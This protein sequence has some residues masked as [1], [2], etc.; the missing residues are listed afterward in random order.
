MRPRP[1]FANAVQ[2]VLLTTC[3]VV[4][5]LFPALASCQ[6]RVTPTQPRGDGNPLPEAGYYSA[7]ADYY[8]GEYRRAIRQYQRL[9]R[10][11]YQD[12]D[13]P[14]LDSVCY[15]TMLGECYYQA[16]DYASAIEMYES[17]IKIYIS[18]SLW[19]PRTQVPSTIAA[20]NTA[21]AQ[22][23]VTWYSSTRSTQIGN[24]PRNYS[25]LF[26]RLDNGR[27]LNEGGVIQ[28]P[29]ARPVDISEAMRCTALSLYRRRQIKG[30]IAKHDP[31]TEQIAKA[32]S[33]QQLDPSNVVGTW[34]GVLAGL[35]YAAAEDW[36]KAA[37]LL[38]QS[39]QVGGTY[40][41]PLTPIALLELGN[42]SFHAGKP[43]D[44]VKLYLEAS[45][46]A[47]VH[48]QYDL[49]E[50]S[51]RLAATTFQLE[52]KSSVFEPLGNA[53]SW[54]QRENADFLQASLAIE[55]AYNLA[56]LGN[57]DQAIRMLASAEQPMARNDIGSST[58]SARM[59]FVSALTQFQAGK[60]SAGAADFA[61]FLNQY[62]E[63]GCLWIYQLALADGLVVSKQ[64]SNR[65]ADALYSLL[66]REPSQLD[67]Q[68]QPM[69]TLTYELTDHT[70]PLE[71]WFNI[72]MDQRKIEKAIDVS[73][74][75]N[76]HRFNVQLPFGGR[77]MAFRWILESPES[78]SSPEVLKLR[79][80]LLNRF[81][82]Y[83]QMHL[84]A[85]QL[86]QQLA[87]LPL[88]PTAD[89][90]EA[91]S[92]GQLV[93]QLAVLSAQQETF[94][95]GLA[96]MRIESPV[97]FPPKMNFADV[98]AGLADDEVAIYCVAA[99]QAL[100]VF[101]ISR[102]S[103][104]HQGAM[105]L[106]RVRAGVGRLLR[107]LGCGSD[108]AGVALENLQG[109]QWQETAVK[110]ADLLLAKRNSRSWSNFD[111]L[112][113]VPGDSTWYLPWEL[114]RVEDEEAGRVNLG[115]L[116]DIRYA[117]TLGLVAPF[118]ESPRTYDRKLAVVSRIFPRDE[119]DAA[120]KTYTQ[121]QT[122]QPDLARLPQNPL[123]SSNVLTSTVD[124]LIV[125]SYFQEPPG[126]TLAP[127]QLDQG[128]AGSTLGDWI[129]LPWRLPQTLVLPAFSSRAATARPADLNGADLFLTTLSMM[130]GGSKT[131]LISR[132]NVGGETPLN[133][134]REFAMQLAEDGPLEAWKR[135]R[136]LTTAMELDLANEPRIRAGATLEAL[137]AEHPFF[138]SGYMLFDSG[139]P[140]KRPA[141]AKAADQD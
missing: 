17:A 113:V 127:L 55:L 97:Q 5:F 35:A 82:L 62:R 120:E 21:V 67:W 104:A 114:L 71:R 3:S 61:R 73:Q 79:Q 48:Q 103:Y 95:S 42:I 105:P 128:R 22:A 40:D 25:Y 98:Q 23:R 88:V 125:W 37:G 107:D 69:E 9:L 84:Q 30:P 58:A 111:K 130:A 124:Q 140:R 87:G 115:E 65:D 112:V 85:A 47:A 80:Q 19:E 138:T 101:L 129:Q 13:G 27:V 54:A 134:S 10:G 60:T 16:G 110:L 49:I 99:Q 81:P 126:Y 133:L 66:L 131:I 89:S 78:A 64:I 36:S 109:N 77:L 116:L 39:L 141:A 86:Q 92:Q 119:S 68:A 57:G 94:L 100:H 46:S 76:Q 11:S 108:T 83:N 34:K 14:F 117:P 56:E 96:L 53:I 33:K 32:L 136:L 121:L 93:K 122:A 118:D 26:G 52:D 31:L 38:S 44:A 45:H 20:D 102:D 139:P 106:N 90:P 137:K 74:Q 91:K 41:H 7:F 29:V 75:L 24:F 4:F 1:L 2:T 132:W 12:V 43:A 15:R 8:Q 63:Q 6:L 59:A 50:H 72:S 51:L 123:G 18:R 70:E 28:N 135:S